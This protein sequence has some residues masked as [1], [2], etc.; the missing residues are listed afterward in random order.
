MSSN[1][2]AQDV[3]VRNMRELPKVGSAYPVY[4]FPYLPFEDGTRIEVSPG[5]F[6]SSYEVYHS[7]PGSVGF[8]VEVKHKGKQIASVA[9]G[10]DYRDG[11][12][13]E[14]VGEAG[15]TDLL[16]VEG[17]NPPS[18][19]GRK[20]S[21][22]YNGQDVREHFN[23]AILAANGRED[24]VVIDLVKSA[25]ERLDHIMEIATPRGRS[26]VLSSKIL[27]RLQLVQMV[28][29]GQQRLPNVHPNDPNIF[30]WKPQKSVYKPEEREMLER[31]GA[32]TVTD[33]AEH[34][35]RYVLIREN[36]EPE[37]LEDL[38]RRVTWIDSTY[39]PYMESARQETHDRRTFADHH[40][41]THLAKGFHATGHK[42]LIDASETGADESILGKLSTANAKMILP[43]HTQ[44][45]G[46]VAKVLHG[47]APDAKIIDQLGHPRSKITLS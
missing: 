35:E 3:A 2:L 5:I 46:E 36:E 40:G 9:Y 32:V 20:E 30:V 44:R 14:R 8:M 43:V 17:T 4:E 24:L 23:E 41:W 33:L 42:P 22:H 25:F 26:I 16:I 1:W 11:R 18:V 19:A 34:P 7:I 39:G 27:K 28:T 29:Q 45:R 13:F 38:G 47:Y 6:V 15:G 12:F 31:Y 21:L 37:K 10:G